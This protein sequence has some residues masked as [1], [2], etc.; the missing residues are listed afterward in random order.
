MRPP[1]PPEGS[2]FRAVDWSEL[3]KR[4]VHVPLQQRLIEHLLYTRSVLGAG[5]SPVN[6]RQKSLPL[7]SL[8]AAGAW[9]GLC[10]EAIPLASL[11]LTC[12]GPPFQQAGCPEREG[13]E[14]AG[15]G[16][17]SF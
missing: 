12:P 8:P 6:K 9:E 2:S 7:R 11:K 15:V 5:D 17:V 10:E 14:A 1:F 4:R 3:L 16:Q 13:K